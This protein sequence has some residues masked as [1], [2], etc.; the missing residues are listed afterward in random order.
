MEKHQN[1]KKG[2]AAT[3][4]KEKEKEKERQGEGDGKVKGTGGS[5]SSARAALGGKSGE[6]GQWGRNW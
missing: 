3:V 6:R 5:V 2:E 1:T 4:K